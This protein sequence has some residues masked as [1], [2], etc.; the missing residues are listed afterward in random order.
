VVEC[1]IRARL[2]C[3]DTEVL[4]AA[5]AG[6]AYDAA[7]LAELPGDIDPCGERGEFHTFVSDGPGFRAPVPYDVGEVVMRGDRFAY[8]DLLPVDSAAVAA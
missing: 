6:R 1:G 8:C 3:V 5:F 4:S 2:V 7:L